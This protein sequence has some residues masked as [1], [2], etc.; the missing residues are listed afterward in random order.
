M[1]RAP[2]SSSAPPSA[3]AELLL[4]RPPGVIRQFWARHPRWA[5]A[6]IALLCLAMSSGTLAASVRYGDPVGA[7]ITM[8]QPSAP[9]TAGVTV[10][11]VA[12]CAALLVRRRLPLLPFALATAG[13]VALVF[14]PV[15]SFSP[16][17]AV[18]VYSLAVYRSN[19]SCWIGYG[20]AVGAV[21]AVA[22][23]AAMLGAVLFPAV[24]NAALDTGVTSLV[25]ALIG[26][27]VGN[28]KR[29]L[30]AVIDRSRQLLVERDQQAQLAAAAERARIAREM[31]DIVAHN[32]TVMVALA[33][34]ATATPDPDRARAATGQIA[35]TGRG[36]LTQ[37][38]AM[39]GVLR[40]D[41]DDAAPR[42]PLASLGEDS[43]AQ[44]VTAARAAGFPVTLATTGGADLPAAVRLALTRTVQEGLT[45][46]MRH[47]PH[48]TG[49]DVAIVY[50]PDAVHVAISN[51]GVTG[52]VRA[53]GYG[54][55]G[56]RERVAHVGGTLEV[57][58]RGHGSWALR[59]RLPFA[60]EPEGG[61]AA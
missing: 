17:L 34:G 13:Q 26:V 38:R 11:V 57:G 18:A 3:D 29:Y 58:P 10:L 1:P 61:E 7:G 54:I 52:P 51:D 27:N 37:M 21:S 31:H 14:M 36:A 45:N 46:A 15:T 22:L 8:V 44:A 39:L 16:A 55:R 47:A 41:D 24:M 42:A 48:A 2:R 33:E 20:V 60:A 5:D 12:T 53:G 30:E 56:L 28:R 32:L 23:L 19:R 40:S 49:I 50:E 25:G 59:A 43:I 35:E 9:A 6:L 4:P